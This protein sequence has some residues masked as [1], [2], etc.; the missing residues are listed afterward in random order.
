MGTPSLST[1]FGPS[2]LT[3]DGITR[4]LRHTF[5]T[6]IHPQ[7]GQN[8]SYTM[9]D[10]ALSA[11]S[12]FFTQSPSFLAYPRRLEPAQG[13]HN[14]RTLFGVHTIPSD[15]PIRSLLDVTPP[16]TLKPAYAFLFNALEQ[17][18]VMDACR[19]CNGTLLL[20]RDGTGYFSSP[21]L[22]CGCGSSRTHANGQVTPCHTR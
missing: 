7:K 2:V 10:A 15:N 4:Q 14:A 3:L 8:K 20:A 11:F 9:V 17:S 16:G 5:A 12:V 22:P 13:N 1:P 19:S 18:G 21:A 6:F